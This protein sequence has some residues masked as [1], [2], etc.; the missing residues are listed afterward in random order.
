MYYTVRDGMGWEIKI[1][2]CPRGVRFHFLKCGSKASQDNAEG[3]GSGKF[4]II[5]PSNE[6]FAAY[7]AVTD[8][9]VDV[10]FT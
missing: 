8:L 1:E 4:S 2:R 5:L 10:P 7:L 6:T 3:S 9:T